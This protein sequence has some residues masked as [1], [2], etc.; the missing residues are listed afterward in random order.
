MSASELWT[1]EQLGADERE[2]VLAAREASQ[3][4]YCRYSGYAVGAAVRAEDGRVFSG[5]NVENASYGLTVC[6]ERVAIFRWVI[7][8]RRGAIE[9]IAVAAGPKDSPPTGGRPCGACL[10]VLREFS[11]DPKIFIVEGERVVETCLSALLPDP[12][13][14]PFGPCSRVATERSD[15]G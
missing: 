8:G 7:D 12:F 2:L 9:A 4:A 15:A 1:P 5:C 14:P 11:I 13:V 3:R 10:Q 6:A